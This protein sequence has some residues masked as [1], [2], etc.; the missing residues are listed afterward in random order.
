M[1]VPIFQE[2]L[3]QLGEWLDVNGEAIYDSSPW[4]YQNDSLNTNV[5]YTCRKKDYNPLKPVAPPSESDTITAV[6]AI[7]LEWPKGSLLT[8]RDL[9]PYM[10]KGIYHIDMLGPKV[11]KNL[12]VSSFCIYLYKSTFYLF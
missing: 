12:N 11:F 4:T 10:H 2:R 8:V 9:S 7:F 1:I 3:L 5:W 6:Y